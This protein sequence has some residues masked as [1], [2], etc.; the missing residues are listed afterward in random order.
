LLILAGFVG[1]RAPEASAIIKAAPAAKVRKKAT[2][3]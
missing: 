2:R 3:R 1:L